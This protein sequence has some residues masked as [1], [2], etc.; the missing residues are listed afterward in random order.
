V[1]CCIAAAYRVFGDVSQI[2]ARYGWLYPLG[3]LVFVYAM[4]RSM[5]MVWVQRGV[6]WRGT[7]Y[8]LRDLRRHNSPFQWKPAPR[9]TRN[10]KMEEDLRARQRSSATADAK[11]A[12]DSGEERPAER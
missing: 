5:V 8:D 11:P 3:A 7:H 4:L 10:Q 6:V 12:G 1:L 2:D 9:K